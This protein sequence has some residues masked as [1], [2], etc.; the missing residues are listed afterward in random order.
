[1]E[2]WLS[3]PIFALP[4]DVPHRVLVVNVGYLEDE[5]VPTRFLPLVAIEHG[6]HMRIFRLP[7]ALFP[8]ARRVQSCTNEGIGI[9]PAEVIFRRGRDGQIGANVVRAG[10]RH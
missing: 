10:S 7:D 6:D 2:T 9:L 4:D 1:M 5:Q 8:W 3:L